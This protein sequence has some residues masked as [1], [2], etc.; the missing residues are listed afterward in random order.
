MP[1]PPLPD[2]SGG[3]GVW[4]IP[5]LTFIKDRRRSVE[6]GGVRLG[7]VVGIMSGDVTDVTLV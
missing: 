4:P 6:S 1:T 5:T 2:G 3:G 7:D